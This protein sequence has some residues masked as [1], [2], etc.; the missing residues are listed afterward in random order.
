MIIRSTA[1]W[2]LWPISLHRFVTE[3][4]L[5]FFDWGSLSA[6]VKYEV[7]ENDFSTMF[8]FIITEMGRMQV[9]ISSF[10]RHLWH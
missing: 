5:R 4:C 8:K 10:S 9:S 2:F 3:R 1:F 6:I 7:V